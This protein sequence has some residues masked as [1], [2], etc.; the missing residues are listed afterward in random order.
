[1]KKTDEY[2][3]SFC[4]DLRR[5]I[6]SKYLIEFHNLIGVVSVNVRIF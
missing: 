1:M 4:V 2:F 3:S 6:L 5:Y